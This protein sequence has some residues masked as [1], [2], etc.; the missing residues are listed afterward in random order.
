MTNAQ[1]PSTNTDSNSSSAQYI[2]SG[3]EQWNQGARTAVITYQGWCCVAR[4]GG[5]KPCFRFDPR[6]IYVSA[7]L[8]LLIIITV[9]FCVFMEAELKC[10]ISARL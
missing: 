2:K 5:K 9:I 1:T 6:V 4:G 10:D 3:V 8:P 7:H